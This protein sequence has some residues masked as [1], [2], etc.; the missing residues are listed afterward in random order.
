MSSRENAYDDLTTI[1]GIKEKRQHLLR[2]ALNVRTYGDLAHLSVDLIESAFRTE[3]KIVSRRAIQ[4]WIAQARR[5]AAAPELRSQP[6]GEATEMEAG[7]AANSPAEENESAQWSVKSA[8]AETDEEDDALA[9]GGEWEWLKAFVVEFCVFRLEG[10]VKKQEIRA[11]PLKVS[12]KGDWLENGETRK[13]PVVIKKG[14]RLYPWMVEQMDEQVWQEPEEEPMTETPPLEAR[15][16]ESQPVEAPPAVE[17][18]QIRAY[19]PRDIQAPTG[20]GQA[21]Q[22]FVGFIMGNEPFALE[23]AFVL[24]ERAVADLV[25]RETRYRAN[26]YVRSMTTGEGTSLGDTESVLVTTGRVAYTARLSDV[27]LQPGRYRLG[28]QV[29]LRSR[30]PSVKHLEVP[31]FQVV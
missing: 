20:I 19:Q 23:V 26:F 10:R 17:V 14:E 25:R 2:Q 15:P 31:M 13:T 30:P 12:K 22:P 1:S 8:E 27:T 11:Y 7:E 6:A 21:S 18:T 28:A 29:K 24:P 4:Q 16:V 5:L 3:G 9:G